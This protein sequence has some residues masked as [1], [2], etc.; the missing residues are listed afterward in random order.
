MKHRFYEETDLVDRLTNANEQND[1]DVVFL[2][3]SAVPLPDHKGGFGVPGT[4]GIVELIRQEFQGS[5]ALE[6]FKEAIS[7]EPKSQY[8]MAFEF[9]HGRRG[10][11]AANAIVRAAVWH[12]INGVNWPETIPSDKV[13]PKEADADIC[14]ALE[15][16]VDVWA[17][18]RAM[19]LLGH[20]LVNYSDTFGKTILTTNFD[21]L[22]EV[23][24]RKHGGL[25]YR[26][27]LP[28]DGSLEQTIS[29]G[30]H[31]IHLHG[32]WSGYDTLHT[33]QQLGHPRPKLKRSL[34]RTLEA[35]TLVVIG[36]GGWDDAIAQ[37]LVEIVTDPISTPEILWTFHEDSETSIEASHDGL[38][39]SLAPG[40]QRGRVLLYRG[41]ECCSLFRKII[42][43]LEPTYPS[44]TNPLDGSQVTTVMNETSP[45][46]GSQRHV[47]IA[48][49]FKL[50]DFGST[51]PDS[52]LI[53]EPWIGRDQEL[54]ILE[55]TSTPV[56]FVTG[57]GGQGK[58][59][60]AGRYL[61]LQCSGDD[62]RYSFWDWR[63]CKE[64]SERLNTQLVCLIERVSEGAID[65]AKIET[66]DFK[67]I[68]DVLFHVLADRSA[69]L[70]FDNVDQYVDL[71]TLGL[72]KGLDYLVSEA[73]AR[74]HNCL[75]LFTCRPNVALDE[76]RSVRLPLQGLTVDETAELLAARG[77]PLGDR[78]LAAELHKTTKG[79]PLWINLIIMQ[80]LR[81]SG[82][83]SAALNAI[84]R[85]G[86][87]LP[88]TTRTIWGML[89][90]QQRDVL[91][92]MAEL[93]RPESESR[94]QHLLPG[95]NFNRVYKALKTLRSYHLVEVR[96]QTEGDP[97]L[98]LHPIIREFI[99]T[100]FPKHDREK[101]VGTILR[102]LDEMIGQFKPL[103]AKEPSYQILEYWARKAELQITF[104]H[105]EDATATIAEIG[106]SFI[107]RGYAEECVRL[108]LRLVRECDWAIACSSFKE[109]DE[110]FE[111]CVNQMIL[112]GHDSVDDLLSRYG[113]AILGKS[114]QYILL[115][116][117]R[118]YSEWYSGNNDAAIRWGEEGEGLKD[119]TAVDTIYSCRH[120]LA[121][122]RRDAGF[123]ATAMESFLEGEDLER[124]VSSGERIDEKD[125]PF[126]GNIGRCLYFLE[127]FDEALVCYVKSAQLLQE[128]RGN[129]DDVNRG[130][131]RLWISELLLP[132]GEVELAAAFLRAAVC[133]WDEVAPPRSAL[134]VERLTEV[135][136]TEPV[137]Q[138]YLDEEG[139]RVEGMFVRWLN[140]Q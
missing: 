40:A 133:I 135:V 137:L 100:N 4:S 12:A 123:H 47:R 127:R 99:R 14:N 20:I 76:S 60:L 16:T 59:A 106:P 97:L 13:T 57:L 80:A 110:V 27:V 87:E 24:I 140:D 79:H 42:E 85:G 93:D 105:F 98:S 55:S 68:V 120:N 17:I 36:Y 58:S 138:G 19:D 115:C 39:T 46:R 35:S 114:S 64:E 108:T 90:N 54:S 43:R 82:G 25:R 136:G 5:T 94:L 78:P 9:L 121:L 56:V 109:F 8:Q 33:P 49:D 2:V 119:E 122:A 10:Q 69:L 22:I 62:K 130:Y 102:F 45:G 41:I 77:I 67:A 81:G 53:V 129:R 50:P 65:T 92:T 113:E 88:D 61:Q 73:Q 11:D 29:E 101:Y 15:N 32:F 111:R 126:Y 103:L 37:T 91:R 28:E 104:S 66:T 95:V 116:N 18:P 128:G 117:L 30:T 74:S 3:G 124:V 107:G 23:S 131:I 125:A 44:R 31:V 86:A 48:V 89:N 71:E 51:E 26:T 84:R 63:D 139:W 34:A 83:L 6:A 112:L 75:F 70:V 38:L 52:P 21:P 134:A 7:G 1:R 118:C 96:T 72:V 132:K